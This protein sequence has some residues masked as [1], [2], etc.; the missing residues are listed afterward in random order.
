MRVLFLWLYAVCKTKRRV[1]R[2]R[3]Q[4]SAKGAW[5]KV[6][7]KACPKN[8]LKEEVGEGNGTGLALLGVGD[9][10]GRIAADEHVIGIDALG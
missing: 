9:V 3:A 4:D 1:L 7:F 2:L 6:D 8:L 10:F 5:S